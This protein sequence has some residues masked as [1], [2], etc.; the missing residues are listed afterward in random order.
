MLLL[1]S[2]AGELS[3]VIGIETVPVTL[4]LGLDELDV[5]LDVLEGMSVVGG[6]AHHTT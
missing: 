4:S 5:E 3:S 6:Y 2:A 1:L